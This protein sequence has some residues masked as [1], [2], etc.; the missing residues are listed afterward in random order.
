VS[1]SDPPKP[2]RD[3]SLAGQSRTL[4]SGGGRG[5]GSGSQSGSGAGRSEIPAERSALESAATLPAKS[6]PP[7]ATEV[8]TGDVLGDRYELLEELG[9]GGE[10]AVFRARD[11]KADTVVA[12]K[13]LAGA[14]GGVKGG[15]RLDRLRRELQMARKITHPGVVRIYDLVE[16]A[17]GYALSMELVDGEPLDARLRREPPLSPGE[18]RALAIDLAHALAAAHEAGV[19][20]R[21]LKPANVLLRGASHRAVVTDFGVSRL[22]DALVDSSSS[23]S[24]SSSSSSSSAAARSGGPQGAE[25]TREGALIGTPAYMA[26][27]QLRGSTRIGPAADVYAFGLV[28]YE[29]AT[30]AR[31]HAGDTIPGL[32]TARTSGA[33]PRLA[34]LRADLDPRLGA[35][36]DRCLAADEHARFASG[37]ELLAALVPRPNPWARAW[38]ALAIGAFALVASGALAMRAKPAPPNPCATGAELA[39]EIWS[40]AARDHLRAAFEATKLPYAEAALTGFASGLEAYAGAW[41][42]MHDDA[43]LATRVRGEQSDEVLDLR[44]RCLADRRADALALVEVAS[45]GEAASVREAAGAPKKLAPIAQCADIQVLKSPV[46]RPKDPAV[47]ARLA[48]L[49]ERAATAQADYALGKS[50]DAMKLSEELLPEATQVGFEPLV[51]RLELLRARVYAEFNDGDKSIPAFHAAFDAGLR[52]GGDRLTREAAVRLAQEYIYA[53]EPKEFDYWA[54]TAQAALA[55]GEPDV[56]LAEFLANLRCVALT[57]TA[58]PR[59]RLACFR[60]FT[61]EVSKRRPLTDWELS[62]LGIA[63][64]DLAD[65]TRALEH[66]RASYE[67]AAKQLGATHPR[68]L[69]MR[70]YTCETLVEQGDL[71]AALKECEDELATLRAVLPDNA[72]LAAKVRYALGRTLL[73]LGRV[74]EA[75]DALAAA[76]PDADS[77]Q[78]VENFLARVE[79]EQGHVAAAITRLKALVARLAK[80]VA[81]ENGS[82]TAARYSL[83]RAYLAKGDARAAVDELTDVVRLDEKNQETPVTI[84]EVR[85]DLARA[86]W[87]AGGEG[88][89]K[90]EPMARDARDVFAA[91]VPPTQ[92]YVATVAAMDAWI[93]GKR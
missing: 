38:P 93:N 77:P 68:A 80:K 32:L 17:G 73:H 67:V 44:M 12:L 90:A 57:L 28:V 83:G 3:G 91:G 18:V 70:V 52:G 41:G 82:L 11:R 81:P 21:D 58:G 60:A 59:E 6:V 7:D 37:T 72:Y 48:A 14:G 4:P 24:L 71:D 65:P 25:L 53:H 86:L 45:H 16:I 47:Q 78:T 89:T 10:G 50:T 87:A 88:R 23:S 20:H 35:I 69:T 22:H 8:T 1:V 9:R 75:H 74:A 61:D 40:D 56:E 55:R 79:V 15:A 54:H 84:A 66:V 26:P 63:E 36:V 51:G 92:L 62:H 85:F 13:L 29:A 76:L 34:R 2:P 39:K 5:G 30:G 46:A 49:E 19:T 33:T 42:T 27:E 31:P 64:L 43:C